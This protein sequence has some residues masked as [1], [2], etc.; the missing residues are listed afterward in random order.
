M[1]ILRGSARSVLGRPHLDAAKSVGG[2][3]EILV[4]ADEGLT[5]FRLGQMQ[6]I[7]KVHALPHPAQRLRRRG[8]IFQTR[9][10]QPP[11]NRRGPWRTGQ[12]KTDRRSAAPT[13]SLAG[14]WC[15]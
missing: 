3:G 11:R 1:A 15:R 9:A 7:R 4:E 10:R 13:R 5:A 6:T 2:L 12:R 14:L 8:S